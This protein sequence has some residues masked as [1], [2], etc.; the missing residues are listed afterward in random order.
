MHDAAI[1]LMNATEARNYAFD[2]GRGRRKNLEDLIDSLRVTLSE[3]ELVEVEAVFPRAAAV[4]ER[5]ASP[6]MKAVMGR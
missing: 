1:V 2:L 5:Y 6:A 4:G 3:K